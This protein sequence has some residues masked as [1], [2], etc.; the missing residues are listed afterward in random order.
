MRWWYC[1]KFILIP[2]SDNTIKRQIDNMSENMSQQLINELLLV[3]PFSIQIDVSVGIENNA[4]LI[5]LVRYR[6][7]NDY[8]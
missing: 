7:C 5:Y 3:K 8:Q 1:K 6:T 2:L 4:Q